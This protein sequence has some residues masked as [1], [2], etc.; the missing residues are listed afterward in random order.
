MA[1]SLLTPTSALSRERLDA[2]VQSLAAAKD[3]QWSKTAEHREPHHHT[4]R[5][6]QPD[7]P[8]P[9]DAQRTF[10]RMRYRGQG[11]ELEIPVQAGDDGAALAARF[12]GSHATRYGFTLPAEAEVVALRHEVGEPA[13]AVRFE[14]DDDP[15]PVTGPATVQ[16]PDATLFVAEGWHATPLPIGGWLL[17]RR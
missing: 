7:S 9:P 3:H 4:R 6:H 11:H 13:R 5:A 8:H 2:A 15:A 17:E 10:A 16:L 12:A 1:M 14:R